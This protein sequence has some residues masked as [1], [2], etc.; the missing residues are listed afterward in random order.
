MRRSSG[1]YCVGLLS[2][3]SLQLLNILWLA[4]TPSFSINFLLKAYSSCTS[5]QQSTSSI[6]SLAHWD[7]LTPED[8]PLC[9]IAKCFLQWPNQLHFS[10]TNIYHLWVDNEILCFD[11]CTRSLLLFE[12]FDTMSH[13]QHRRRHKCNLV[14][15]ENWNGYMATPL[16]VPLVSQASSKL[17]KNSA[18]VVTRNGFGK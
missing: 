13:V 4:A 2:L 6:S 17:I 18:I 9:M 1:W 12:F 11:A 8:C 3:S 14:E 16:F 5:P 15:G 7:G 10:S